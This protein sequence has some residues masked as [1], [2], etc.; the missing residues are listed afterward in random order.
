E[1]QV[2]SARARLQSDE[3]D[4]DALFTM[5]AYFAVM[6]QHQEALMVL[7]ELGALDQ[8]YPGLWWLKTRVF[9][10]MGKPL[11]ASSARKI[12]MKLGTLLEEE[13]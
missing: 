11:A 3:E 5:G 9:Q 6:G 7:N 4:R 10:M 12:A 13:H 1:R 2:K 8:E